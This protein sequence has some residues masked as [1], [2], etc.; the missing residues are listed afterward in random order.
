M[1]GHDAFISYSRKDKT[2]AEQLEKALEQYTPPKELN[3]PQRHLDIFRDEEDFTGTEYHHSLE[4]H[5]KDSD[6][7]I[8]L[9]SP[10]SHSSQYV[11][12]EIRRFAEE[13][14][15]DNIISLLVGGIPNNEAK[16]GQEAECAFPE[17]L[18]EGQDMPLAANY[19]SFNPKKDKINKGTFE[20]AWYTTL[21]NIYGISRSELEQR[22]TKR[23]MQE[24]RARRWRRVTISLSSFVILLTIIV[25]GFPL[26]LIQ[27]LPLEIALPKSVAELLPSHSLR[28]GWNAQL[29]PDER[30]RDTSA[31][32]KVGS[33][34][35]EDARFLGLA[36][37]GVGSRSMNFAGAVML[38]LQERGIL[39]Q[40][41]VI[42][43]VS[44]GAV[45]AMY[46]ALGPQNAGPFTPEALRQRLAIDLQRDWIK[47]WFYPKNHF[48]VK[49]SDF[50]HSDIFVQVLNDHL[51]RNRTFSDLQPHPK[52]L[53]S[54]TSTSDMSRFTFTD[55]AFKQSLGS[56]LASYPVASA[57]YAS[58][59]I[60]GIFDEVTLE[61]YRAGG[62]SEYLHLSDGQAVDRLAMEAVIEFLQRAVAGSSLD[63]LFPRGCLILV[64]DSTPSLDN[65][66][67]WSTAYTDV[68]DWFLNRNLMTW[69]DRL[70]YPL[71]TQTLRSL[72]I[73]EVDNQTVGEI[74]IAD[75]HFC[76]CTIHHLA[77]RHLAYAEDYDLAYRVTG[78]ASKFWISRE[79]QNDL[80]HAAKLL[81]Q[82]LPDL[83][84]LTTK[85]GSKK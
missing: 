28:P 8:V 60:P 67:H 38:E 23:Q 6:K 72:G 63:R 83:S 54:A 57:V 24:R 19:L 4:K 61:Q 26:T 68:Y 32:W 49:F 55:E 1:P 44:G 75:R 37:S 43:A 27:F 78:I 74:P 47:R 18:C 36:I 82:S 81:V 41:D 39:Q 9:C 13:K 15:R 80:F 16:P 14:G 33:L 31:S 35:I 17:T 22:E 30:T 58:T 5:L 76:R 50:T 7:L 42:S 71:R 12:E 64:I 10:H 70:T 46:Y 45:P 84:T 40:V 52:L 62:L 34:E 11:N 21:A 2:F 66:V 73:K 65:E 25:T 56:S 53:V 29:G 3:V 85:C 59:A 20:G 48:L 79:E 77:L 51:Y 69:F